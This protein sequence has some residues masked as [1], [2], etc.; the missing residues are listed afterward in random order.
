G[1]ALP[2]DYRLYDTAYSSVLVS[3][4]GNLQFTTRSGSRFNTCLPN[5]VLGA[6]LLPYWT[7]LLTDCKN[8]GVYTST[9]GTAPTRVFNIEWRAGYFK[10]VGPANFEVRLYETTNI[11]EFVYGQMAEPGFNATVGVQYPG[12]TFFNQYECNSGGL[13]QGLLVRGVRDTCVPTPTATPSGT[14]TATRTIT[15]TPPTMTPTGTRTLTPTATN[16]PTGTMTSTIT[17]TVTR[18]PTGPGTRTL[19]PT[20][21]ATW[22]PSATLPV[23]ITN[24]PTG[25]ATGP[26]AVT[27]TRTQPP[28]ATN[29]PPSTPC[30]I[31]FT[32]VH[33]T[34]YFYEGVRWLYCHGAISGYADNTFRPY[35][36]TTRGQMAKILILAFGH[37]IYI[38]TSLT[39][40]DVPETNPFFR[41]IETAFH[42]GIVSGYNCGGPGEPCPG[43]YYR[44]GNLITRGQLAKIITLAAGWALLDPPTGRFVDVPRSHTFYREIETVYCHQVISGY[45]CGG[46]GEPCPGLYFRPGGNAIRGQIAKMVYNAVSDLPSSCGR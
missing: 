13:T 36:N 31:G 45:S 44:P 35:V 7:D 9:T 10:G 34:D 19:S 12:A 33:T 41:Y 8:C 4:N 23:E 16:T 21:T 1:I 29:T 6:A 20:W 46:P 42:D 37:P 40:R 18:T 30:A 32:D 38:P 43:L 28:S 14:R 26:R 3:S 5:P 27:P 39:F 17:R 25:T 22:T 2:F 24:T 11:F 15:G